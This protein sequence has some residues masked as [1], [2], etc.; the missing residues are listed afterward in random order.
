MV[1]GG[2]FQLETNYHYTMACSAHHFPVPC[3]TVKHP[4]VQRLTV[5]YFLYS[6]LLYNMFLYSIPC[7]AFYCIVHNLFYSVLLHI[8]SCTTFHLHITVQ[9]FSVQYYFVYML[10]CP[11][12]TQRSILSSWVHRGIGHRA[13]KV[14]PTARPHAGIRCILI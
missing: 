12:D 6:I 2:F 4:S 3:A 10:Y 13:T 5:Q 8:I 1:R 14:F 11:T 9:Q 7:R